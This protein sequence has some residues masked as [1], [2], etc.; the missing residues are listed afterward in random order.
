M[1]AQ[2]GSLRGAHPR[3][4]RSLVGVGDKIGLATLPFLVVGLALNVAYPWAFSVGGP[5]AWLRTLSIVVLI[6]GVVLW[7]WSVVLVL[8]KVPRAELIT[9]GPFALVKHPLYTFV[10]LLVLPWAG[11]LLDSWLGAALGVV[12]YLA[13]RRYA[14]LEE[15]ELAEA[16]GSGWDDYC[17][18]LLIPWL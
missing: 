15:A 16:F 7:I 10:P 5:P 13:D 3:G 4:L 6:P 14:P 8:T 9:T 12:M 1:G 18:E 17:G 2:G 11:F